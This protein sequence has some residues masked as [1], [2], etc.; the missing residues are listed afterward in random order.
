MTGTPGRARSLRERVVAQ[1]ARWWRGRLL[2]WPIRRRLAACGPHLWIGSRVRL[3]NPNRVFLG[4]SVVMERDCFIGASP[5]GA[6]RIGQLVHLAQGCVVACGNAEITIGPLTIIGEYTSI[7]NTNHG[8]SRDQPIRFQDDTHAPIMI[9]SDVWIGRGCAILAGVTIGDGAVVG[10]NSVVTSD[11][12]PY[13]IVAGN[14]ARFIRA[15]E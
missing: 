13:T 6:L 4:D 7:R 9:G 5:G 15:R 12:D 2:S 3:V 10:A 14:P 11:V 8:M 1:L